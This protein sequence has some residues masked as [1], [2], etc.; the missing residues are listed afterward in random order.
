MTFAS[1]FIGSSFVFILEET[2]IE[3]RYMFEW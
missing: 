3:D 1:T 2:E